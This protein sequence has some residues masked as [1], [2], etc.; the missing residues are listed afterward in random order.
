[1][2]VLAELVAYYGT[3]N[4]CLKIIVIYS[5]THPDYLNPV[6]HTQRGKNCGHNNLST[7]YNYKWTPRLNT[8]PCS[9]VRVHLDITF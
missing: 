4:V 8:L 1:M 2:S 9:L 5:D 6:A 3:N 7:V